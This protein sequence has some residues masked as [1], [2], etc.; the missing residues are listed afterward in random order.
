MV[1]ARVRVRVRVRVRI[2]KLAEHEPHLL[3]R[4]QQLAPVQGKA[5]TCE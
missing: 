1:R 3:G 2:S 4:V 5:H